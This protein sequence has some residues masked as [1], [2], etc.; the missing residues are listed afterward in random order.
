L[1]AG[2]ICVWQDFVSLAEAWQSVWQ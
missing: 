1:A 2:F